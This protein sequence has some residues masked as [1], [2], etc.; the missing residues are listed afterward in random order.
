MK[1]SNI[2]TVPAALANTA[3]AE[4]ECFN[5]YVN[6]PEGR[7]I[8]CEL[9]AN[10]DVLAEY[11]D[12]DTLASHEENAACIVSRVEEAIDHA[13]GLLSDLKSLRDGY[14]DHLGIPEALKE[15][16]LA[17][18][19]VD[20]EQLRQAFGYGF[21]LVGASERK[22]FKDLRESLVALGMPHTHHG[23]V[24]KTYRDAYWSNPKRWTR[25]LLSDVS[26]EATIPA[27]LGRESE[28]A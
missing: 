10:S 4:L 13:E 6:S 3:E 12:L 8:I 9:S 7:D 11:S 14:V 16:A 27:D 18:H 21:E 28:A 17:L 24:I 25:S 15:V 1:T 23:R 20:S 5:D 26:G 19:K 22:M 2:S